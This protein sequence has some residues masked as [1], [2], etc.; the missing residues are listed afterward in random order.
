MPPRAPRSDRPPLRRSFGQHHLRDGGICAP[1]V[2]FLELAPGTPVLE[3]GAGGGVLTRELL[4][5]GACVVALEL[6]L[7]WAFEL[8]RRLRE[9]P[10]PGRLRIVAA[11]ALELDWSRLPVGWRV[12]GTCRTTSAP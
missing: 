7:G 1:L 5:R 12:P 11:D 8:A 3:I 4:A 2:D 10:A 6:D 9:A